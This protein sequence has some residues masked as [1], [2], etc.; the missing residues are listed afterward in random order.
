MKDSRLI[1]TVDVKNSEGILYLLAEDPVF[2]EIITKGDNKY[3]FRVK[4]GK[5]KIKAD[6]INKKPIINIDLELES[7]LQYQY[8]ESLI[9]DNEKKVLEKKI[10][11]MVKDYILE[12]IK[13]SQKEFECD[14]FRFAKYFRADFPKVYK[15]IDWS[16]EYS[17]IKVNVNVKSKIINMN[18]S[19]PNAKQ[20]Y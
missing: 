4:I 8:Y 10:S 2:T 14:I 16:E 17:N 9:T 13:K 12:I 1:A 20:K 3:S 15:N 7:Q 11:D 19:D 18:F 5:R 6:Y